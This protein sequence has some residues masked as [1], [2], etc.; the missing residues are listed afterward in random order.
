MTCLYN[1]NRGLRTPQSNLNHLVTSCTCA[2]LLK[3]AACCGVGL[4]SG[5]PFCGFLRAN[6]ITWLMWIMPAFASV[7]SEC[8]SLC[9]YVRGGW[10]RQE[11][12]R[13]ELKTVIV[14][15]WGQMH[16]FGLG[17][18]GLYNICWGT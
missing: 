13:K 4:G 15:V 17:V 3:E 10:E 11:G 7:E 8:V 12:K 6:D 9:V 5:W 18:Q 2:H 1:L 14:T 16:L